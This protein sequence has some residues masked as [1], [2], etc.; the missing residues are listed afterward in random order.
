MF[1][2]RSNMCK[3]CEKIQKK[4][5]RANNIEKYKKYEQ[6]EKYKSN[7]KKWY[8]NNKDYLFQYVK[9]NEISILPGVYLV[10]NLINGKCYI[11]QSKRPYKRSCEHFTIHNSSKSK[12]F[13]P[14][15]QSDLKQYGRKSFVF[16]IIEH[17]EINQL[18]EREQYYINLYQ[19]QYN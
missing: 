19:P 15:I 16:G 1:Y 9:N 11:G 3:E 18:L 2:S 4:I 17:C 10:K 13:N 12:A 6:S 7:T 5:H 14:N 8:K